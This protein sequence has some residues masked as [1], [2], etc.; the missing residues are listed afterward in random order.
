MIRKLLSQFSALLKSKVNQPENSDSH[1]AHVKAHK[2]IEQQLKLEQAPQ[3]QINLDT[4]KIILPENLTPEE[5][6]EV[7]A[8]MQ[9]LKESLQKFA[10]EELYKSLEDFMNN[11]GTALEIPFTTANA[12][13]DAQD[14]VVD[15]MENHRYD[16]E[17]WNDEDFI[18]ALFGFYNQ[19]YEFD[20]IE[21]L[22]NKIQAREELSPSEKEKLRNWYVLAS[23]ELVYDV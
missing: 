14:Q 2:E 13:P 21:V 15:E 22:A 17:H 7:E 16:T 23:Q 1:E 19:G 18:E 8:A 6:A 9:E 3:V 5:K 10:P 12:L 20:G 4:G 11:S